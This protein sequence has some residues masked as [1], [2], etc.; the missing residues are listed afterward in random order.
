MEKTLLM[1]K[2]EGMEHKNDIISRVEQVGLRIVW[3]RK[4]IATI[5]FLRKLYKEQ[6]GGFWKVNKDYLLGKECLLIIVEGE[7]AASR[8]YHLCG[9]HFDP[10]QCESGTIRRQ[11]GEGEPKVGVNGQILFLNAV[12][13]STPENAE[14]ETNLC[15]KLYGEDLL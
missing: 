4:I 7:R 8:L 14:Y 11:F 2:P 1:I 12:H 5:S 10:N 3:T 13:R 9:T 15:Y 6:S